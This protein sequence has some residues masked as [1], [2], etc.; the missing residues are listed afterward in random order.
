MRNK[1]I[2][3]LAVVF[4]L[5]AALLVFN[6]LNNVNQ[7]AENKNYTQVVTAAQE[8]PANTKITDAMLVL[9]PFP[10]ELRNNNEVVDKQKAVGKIS[11]VAISEGE[12]LFENRLVKP[13][14]SS[15]RLSYTIPDGLRAISVPVDEVT[16]VANMIQKGDRVDIISVVVPDSTVPPRSVVVLQNI[17]VLAIGTQLNPSKAPNPEKA[18]PPK[19]VTLAVNLNDSLRLKIAQQEGG[20]SLLLRSPGDNS[21]GQAAPF[22]VNQF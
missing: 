10:T 13:G 19:T 21:F 14:E 8:I 7:V 17:E 2:L 22:M 18:T 12:V 9:K 3:V 5:V 6:Y 16:G 1:L 11:T 20:I 15:E 4:G